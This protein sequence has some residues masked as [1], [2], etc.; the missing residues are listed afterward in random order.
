[1][2]M[3]DP[4][5]AERYRRLQTI[6][7]RGYGLQMRELDREFGQLTEETCRT[8]ID[9]MEMY[10]ALHVSWTNL[11]DAAGIDERRVTFL[12][13]DAAT[14][15]R[16]LGY[17]RFMVNIEG[18]YSH[19]DAGTHG[20]NSQTPMWEKY[21]RML[22]I[23]HDEILSFI[24][25]KQAITSIRHFMPGRSEEDIQAEFRFLEQIEATDIEGIVALPGAL[26]LLSTLNE[27]GIPWAIVTSGSVPVAHAR[28]RAAG[29]PMPEVFITAEQ[30][31]HGKPAPDAYLLGAERLGLPADQCAVVEDAPAGLL[32]G[33]AA[34]C[35]TIAVNVPADAPRLDEA[36]LVL[37]SLDDLVI[38][39]QA[40][41]Y[42]NVRLKA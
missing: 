41:G 10:H 17:V 21:Q 3:L 1:M 25:G 34:G 28:H 38:E 24:H 16:F 6:I 12:G 26:T 19:F 18:R 22:S 40:D 29:L 14:E 42:V 2:T 15:A 37:S 39:R 23:D 4:D 33:L 32:S 7:E 9:I 36:D 11:K 20:F 27:A 8:V 13:F 31:K 5:N 30:V 35:R